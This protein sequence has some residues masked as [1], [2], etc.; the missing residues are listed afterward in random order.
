MAAET[1]RGSCTDVP[2]ARKWCRIVTEL[3]LIQLLAA[4]IP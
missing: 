4:Q 2:S 3:L 1:A